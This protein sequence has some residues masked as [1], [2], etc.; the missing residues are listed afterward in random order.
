VAWS[1]KWEEPAF[2]LG[3]LR[4]KDAAIPAPSLTLES[5]AQIEVGEVSVASAKVALNSQG[6]VTCDADGVKVAL[7]GGKFKTGL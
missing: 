3:N 4:Y 5:Q 7:S 6:E 1:G 2:M